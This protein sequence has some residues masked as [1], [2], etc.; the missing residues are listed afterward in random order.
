M[1]VFVFVVKGAAN[2]GEGFG[3]GKDLARN[4]EIVIFR[5]DGMPVHT[6]SSYR[7]FRH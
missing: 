6:L 1:R 7:D 5:A 3:Q 4:K 2:G